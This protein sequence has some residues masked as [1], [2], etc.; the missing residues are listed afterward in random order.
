MNKRKLW[1]LHHCEKK[2]MQNAPDVSLLYGSVRCVSY[3]CIL[4]VL[5]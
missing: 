5:Q 1:L 4:R 3:L 2:Q